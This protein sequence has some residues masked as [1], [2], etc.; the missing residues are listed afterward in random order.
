MVS[1]IANTTTYLKASDEDRTESTIHNLVKKNY[2][3][4]QVDKYIV[5]YDT[6]KDE[7]YLFGDTGKKLD[8]LGSQVW[9][10]LTEP[11]A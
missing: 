5:K 9:K 8:S 4:N 1:Q 7:G 3:V 10:N 11:A 2:F 6:A